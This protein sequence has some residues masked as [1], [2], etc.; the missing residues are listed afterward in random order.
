M[1]GIVFTGDSYCYGEGLQYFSELDTVVFPDVHT[2]DPNWITATQER[3]IEENRYAK[4]AAKKLNHLDLVYAKNGGQD[5]HII[6]EL[7]QKIP[8]I[9]KYSEISAVIVNL[10][11]PL[12]DD[13]EF[14]HN[15]KLYKS[16]N[17]NQSNRDNDETFL[18]LAQHVEEI[19]GG[20]FSKFENVEYRKHLDKLK[21]TFQ[22]FEENG[23]VCRWINWLENGYEAFK[24]DEYLNSRLIEIEDRG[25]TFNSTRKWMVSNQRHFIRNHFK[26]I[27]KCEHDDHISPEGHEV[28]A[29]SIYNNLKNV[30]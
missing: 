10:T 1:K 2:Y 17:I 28:M 11:N 23:I 7:N 19:H 22:K 5:L 13:F 6:G 24:D 4:L 26:H 14:L 18:A 30:I 9:Y 20:D 16:V 29:N 12:R 3:F 8:Q 27:N 25:V 15:G 21:E